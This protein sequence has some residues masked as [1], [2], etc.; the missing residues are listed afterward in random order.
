MRAPWCDGASG[1][2]SKARRLD[3]LKRNADAPDMLHVCAPNEQLLLAQ[4]PPEVLL[5]RLP[6][7]IG[8]DGCS[9]SIGLDDGEEPRI[10]C[11]PERHERVQ[12][13]VVV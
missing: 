9:I 13:G 8:M 3:R 4:H 2:L 12:A 7:P 5:N 6:R 1:D 11:D 10:I